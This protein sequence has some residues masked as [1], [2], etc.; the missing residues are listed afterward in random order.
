[1]LVITFSYAPML[2]ARAFRWTAL[3]AHFAA[4]GWAVDVLTSRQPGTA[5][6]EAQGAL[7]VHRA[8][9][10]WAEALRGVLRRQRGQTPGA[11]P[12]RR[13]L[14]ARLLQ[15]V[16][17]WT[18]RHVYWPDSSCLWY[19]PARRKALELV[20]R[21]RPDV[22]ISVCP[23]FTA[24]LVGRAAQ[25]AAPHVRWLIDVGDPFSLQV[26]A[27]P[28]NSA[29]YG[30]LNRRVE[31]AALLRADAVAVTTPHTAGRY[32]DA[33][34]AAAPKIHVIP[35]LLSAP[36]APP[37]APLFAADG[38]VRLVYVGT[39]YRGLREPRFLAELL[40][41]LCA[42]QPGERY[43]LHLYGD[44][45]EFADVLADWRRRLGAALQVHGMVPRETIARAIESASVLVNIGNS[46]ADQ[47]PS[48]VVEYAASG[49]PILNIVRQPEDS[50]ARFLESYPDKLLLHD[51]GAAPSAAQLAALESFIARLPRRLSAERIESWLAP[52]RLPRIAAQYEKLMR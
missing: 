10:S 48:K 16:R 38:V 1:M 34:P 43:E 15:L 41:A 45:H 35:P 32:A 39:L 11:D 44:V 26:D 42:R 13:G 3:A 30:P 31:H 22:V 36:A 47:L 37:D 9:W 18:W 27:A 4:N 50:S 49:K 7:R 33:F 29:L 17:H 24:V 28:N 14:P 8:G 2:N 19:W 51:R 25:R 6:S 20:S 5:S 23:T 21:Q 52:Y 40:Q 46:S 12:G